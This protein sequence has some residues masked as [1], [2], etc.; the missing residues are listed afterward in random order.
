MRVRSELIF[1]PDNDDDTDK[2]EDLILDSVTEDACPEL[3]SALWRDGALH[4]VDFIPEFNYELCE[5]L[6]NYLRAG[7]VEGQFEYKQSF[8]L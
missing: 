4:V 2:A 8:W 5:Y 1:R 6:L 7:G 3:V